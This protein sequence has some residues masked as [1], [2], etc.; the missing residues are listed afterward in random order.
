MFLQD[1]TGCKCIAASFGLLLFVWNDT[2]L[3]SPDLVTLTK[4]KHCNEYLLC[5]HAEEWSLSGEQ[6]IAMSCFAVPANL[7]GAQRLMGWGT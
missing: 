3:D 6:I 2:L 5:H 1:G 7:M 4:V